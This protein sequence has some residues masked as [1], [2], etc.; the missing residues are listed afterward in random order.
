MAADPGPN[1]TAWLA[2]A[3]RLRDARDWPA[4]AAAYGRW[5]ALHPHD[6]AVAIQHGH[7]L[8]EAGDL[9][10]ALAAYARAEYA[11]P[12]DADLQLQIG[13]ARKRLGD[14]AGAQAAY[15]RALDLAPT[16]DAA[17]RELAGLAGQ[18]AL[19]APAEA[20][21]SLQGELIVV[22]DLSDLLSWFG[23]NRAPSGIQ[24]VQIEIVAAALR[25]GAPA[26]QVLL[27]GFHAPSGTWRLLPRPVFQRL[28][29]LSAS[30]AD[31][32]DPAWREAVSAAQGSI[33]T[34][35]ALPFP[36]GAWLVNI[37]TSWDQP[38]YELALR[39][40]RARGRLRY[41]ALVHDCGPLV[42]PEHAE[43]GLAARYAAW[44]ARVALSADL[45]LASSVATREEAEAL[46]TAM[47]PGL[48]A[49]PIAPLPFD[50]TPPRAP[51][52]ATP[53]AGVAALAGRR[54][55]LC[56]STLESRKDHLFLLHAWLALHRAHGAKLPKLVLVGRPGFRAEEVF[57]LLR[58]SPVLTQAVEVLHDVAD[59]ALVRLYQGALFTLYNSHHEGWG[60]PVTEAIGLGKVVVAPGLP[61]LRQAGLGHALHFAPGSEPG[62]RALVEPLLFEPGALARAEAAVRGAKLRRWQDVAD[63]LLGHLITAEDTPMPPPPVPLGLVLH[64][65]VPRATRPSP[66]LALAEALRDGPLWHPPEPFGCWT[67]PGRARLRLHHAA[68]AGTQLRLLVTLR[69]PPAGLR[70]WLRLN[71]EPA[72]TLEIAP[73]A[74]ATAAL[75]TVAAGDALD[76]VLEAPAA[77]TPPSQALGD[78][79]RQVGVGFVS[80][81]LCDATDLAAR[82]DYLE[83]QRFVWP[84]LA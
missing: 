37:G 38:D 21:L 6:G 32:E 68:A 14:I 16:Q 24:R 50:A 23:A 19:A 83:R 46:R 61:A 70:V 74:Q 3:D 78:P 33:A 76:L 71:D 34:G 2:E 25:P 63:Q 52:A 80:L 55:V 5:L 62:F 31:T 57:A 67:K 39:R 75:D 35:S 66:A 8:K 36:E 45:L 48:P 47:L 15:A 49:P 20:P 60:L 65:G 73:D 43:A 51:A 81:M 40:A 9:H 84:E 17:W 79:P 22:F 4:A 18:G 54:Y 53:H 30:G 82:I 58:A 26:G 29:A 44:F 56:V 7:C 27:A 12:L 77:E 10:G 69:A 28:V 64:A 72:R 1:V 11:R 42:V 41:A 59:E 13:H